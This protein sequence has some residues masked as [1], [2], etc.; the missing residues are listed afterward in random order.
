[1]TSFTG[2]V[3]LKLP[4]DWHKLNIIYALKKLYEEKQ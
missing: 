1:M 4:T 3:P 2:H